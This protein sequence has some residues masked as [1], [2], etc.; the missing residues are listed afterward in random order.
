MHIRANGTTKLRVLE[1]A[2]PNFQ[3]E[4]KRYKRQSTVVGGQ[5]IVLDKPHP[6]SVSHLMD[7]LRYL[8]AAD[9]RYH[10]PEEKRESAWWEG[11]IAKRRRE[12]GEESNVVYLAP[13]SYTS[14]TYVA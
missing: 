7:C 8:M 6:R 1:G 5:S 9:I 11:W 13:S 4:I 12:R 14:Q 2:L 10:K 3:R